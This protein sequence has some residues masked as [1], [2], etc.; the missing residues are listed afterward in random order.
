MGS[1]TVSADPHSPDKPINVSISELGFNNTRR[2]VRFNLK[3]LRS[4]ASYGSIERYEVLV[5]EESE[6][7]NRDISN[8]QIQTFS[9]SYV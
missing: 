7:D 3:W 1:C 5:T 6:I 9:V 4:T 2:E 8:G